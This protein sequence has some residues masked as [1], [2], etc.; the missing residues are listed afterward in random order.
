MALLDLFN[1]IIDR[2][3]SKLKELLGPFGK[4]FDLLGKFWTNLRTF[5]SRVLNLYQSILSEITAWRG[6]R[7]GLRARTRVVNLSKAIEQTQDLIEEVKQAWLAVKDLIQNLKGKFETTGNPTEEAEEAIKDIEGS[8][9][10]AILEK[11][12]RLAKGLEK[13]LGF[14]AILADAL[15]SISAGVD[16]LQRIL[17]TLRDLREELEFGKTIFLNQGNLRK[18][19]TLSDGTKMKIRLGNLHPG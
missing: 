8:G 14:V 11:F 12:P 15:E 9:F 7:A 17:D 4:L 2:L 18:T 19:V 3:L 10:K 16:D 6:F 1:P 5:G 13:V